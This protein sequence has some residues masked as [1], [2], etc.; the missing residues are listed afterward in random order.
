MQI[1]ANILTSPQIHNFTRQMNF[2]LER[3]IPPF[4][5]NQ[6]RFCFNIRKKH[7][8]L[9]RQITNFL[10]LVY[11]SS[12]VC[13]RLKKLCLRLITATS[14]MFK[15]TRDEVHYKAPRMTPRHVL[16]AF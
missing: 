15:Q 10:V 6:I 2:F 11:Q 1:Y 13:S 14:L 8:P 12:K 9:L 4:Y 3:L 16:V 5:I 7:A